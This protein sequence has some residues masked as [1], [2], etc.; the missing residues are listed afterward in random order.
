MPSTV[1]YLI[2]EKGTKTSVVI[3]LKVWE[4]INDYYARLQNKIGIFTGIKKGFKEV[5]DAK[6][7]GMKLETL[8]N[9]LRERMN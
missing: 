3:P 8:N 7:N 9:F 2:D 6:K 4:K 1:N 5:R